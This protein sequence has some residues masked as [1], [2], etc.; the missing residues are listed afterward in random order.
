MKYCTRAHYTIMAPARRRKE[1]KEK[2]RKSTG[3]PKTPR[4][5]PRAFSLMIIITYYYW[6]Y[7]VLP[8]IH[9]SLLDLHYPY[10][11]L[12]IILKW[13]Q[14]GWSGSLTIGR[15]ILGK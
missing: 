3:P 6:N 12:F 15:S 11:I 13:W 10:S 4:P 14:I 7:T 2:K 8:G 9:Y 1:K 5:E